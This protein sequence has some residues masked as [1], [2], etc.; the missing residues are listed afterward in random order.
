MINPYYDILQVLQKHTEIPH[1]KQFL[2]F[3]L[4]LNLLRCALVDIFSWA[5]P[6]NAAILE[7]R[8]CEKPILEV[9]AGRGYWQ[10]V[11]DRSEDEYIATDKI[12]SLKAWSTV[13]QMD[14]VTAVK[15]YPDNILLFVWPQ[16][17]IMDCLNHYK[18][19]WLY[20]I[21]EGSTEQIPEGWNVHKIIEIPTWSNMADRMILYKREIY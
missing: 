2:G 12:T 20:W 8:N 3:R 10:F 4:E 16:D 5:I 9:G 11:V 18:Q 19:N 17:N 15:K 14:S 21:G 6:N 13:Y 7:L 1:A